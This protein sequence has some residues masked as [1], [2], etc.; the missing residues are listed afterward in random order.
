[1]SNEGIPSILNLN[2]GAQRL[3]SFVIR[4]S[5]IVIPHYHAVKPPSARSSMPV[6]YD[7]A[8]EAKKINGPRK[9]AA[10]AILPMGTRLQNLR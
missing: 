5:L 1:M 7:D 8:C 9:S 2:D 10:V 3:P 6:T 4:H